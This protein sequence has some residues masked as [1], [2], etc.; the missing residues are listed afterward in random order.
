MAFTAPLWVEKLGYTAMND[1][2]LLTAALNQGVIAREEN[3]G[4]NHVGRLECEPSSGM[5]TQIGTGRAAIGGFGNSFQLQEGLYVVQNTAPVLVTHV[6]AHPTLPRI[7]QIGVKVF[8]STDGGDSSDK[9]EPLVLAGTP[10][11]GATLENR[12]GV[13]GGSEGQNFP[14]NFLQLYEVLVPAAA[15]SASSFSYRDFRTWANGFNDVAQVASTFTTSSTAFSEVMGLRVNANNWPI[16]MISGSYELT[17]A[18]AILTILLSSGVGGSGAEL[19]Y[20]IKLPVVTGVGTFS[21]MWETL[22]VW[23]PPALGSTVMTLKAKVESGGTLKILPY[24][25]MRVMEMPFPAGNV[26][27]P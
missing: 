5:S 7:D 9:A 4:F 16:V 1:R 2:Q 21:F 26:N 18:P 24:S 10:T 20:P 15:S 13:A 25:T 23:V 11:S 27:S 8:D 6:T 19:R 22:S 17:T 14:N 12:L 3:V